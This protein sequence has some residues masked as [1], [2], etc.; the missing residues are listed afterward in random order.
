KAIRDWLATGGNVRVQHNAQRDPASVGLEVSTD[1]SGATW[2]KS[3]IVEDGAKKLLLAKAL[4]AYSVGIA[5]PTIVR[6]PVAKGGRITSGTICEISLVDRPSNARCGVT[7]VKSAGDGTPEYVGEV[8]GADDDIAKALDA[9]L[10]KAATDDLVNVDLPK[11]ASIS[12]SPADFAALRTFKQQLTV[13]AAGT[14][15]AK[16]DVSTAE[17]QSLA[18]EGNALPDGSYPISSAG[19]LHNAAHLARTGHGDA[20]AARKL[21]ARRARELGV[22]NPLDDDSTSKGTVTDTADKAAVTGALTALDK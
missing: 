8:F 1:E 12:I 16:R 19:D 21:I 9:D 7:L 20:D 15:T 18:S 5:R 22:A 17:R 2:V 11:G 3:L 6:D 13:K 14:D 10:T 4:T